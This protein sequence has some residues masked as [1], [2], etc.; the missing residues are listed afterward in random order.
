MSTEQ[1]FRFS[2]AWYYVH[3]RLPSPWHQKDTCKNL[4]L[5]L[6]C[7]FLLDKQ[8]KFQERT[9]SAFKYPLI[10]NNRQKE[11]NLSTKDKRLGPKYVHYLEVPLY[12]KMLLWPF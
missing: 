12:I 6:E 3:R 2:N 4:F 11:D 5:R 1:K 9:I 7:P 8:W 10:Q